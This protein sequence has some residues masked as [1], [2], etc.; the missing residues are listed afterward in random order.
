MELLKQKRIGHSRRGRKQNNGLCRNSLEGTLAAEVVAFMRCAYL[1]G[2]VSLVIILE[3]QLSR[4]VEQ[5]QAASA[6]NGRPLG[7]SE[8]D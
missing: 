8:N 5:S 6:R 4:N 7:N 1:S 2:V 3:A